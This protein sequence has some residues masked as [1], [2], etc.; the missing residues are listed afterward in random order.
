VRATVKAASHVTAAVG[1]ASH[2]TAA[3]AATHMAAAKAPAV[4]AAKAPATVTAAATTVAAPAAATTAVTQSAGQTGQTQE[5]NGSDY[6]SQRSQTGLHRVP[7]FPFRT[8]AHNSDCTE[9]PVK[10]SITFEFV[11]SCGSLK[12]TQDAYVNSGRLFAP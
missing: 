1:A 2:V 10:G 3:E 9:L 5:R 12:S 11:M 6:G 4:T 7:L 8:A